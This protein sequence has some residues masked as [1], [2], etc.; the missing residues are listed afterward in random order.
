MNTPLKI[1]IG[2][3]LVAAVVIKGAPALAEPAQPQAVSIVHTADL[4]LSSEAG[5]RQLDQRFV[6]AAREVCG[7]ASDVDLE[8]KNEVRACRSKVLSDARTQ[9][10]QLASRVGSISIAAAR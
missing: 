2:S 1:A 6:T 7:S 4:D 5:R 9:G 8:G 10:Q 3:F